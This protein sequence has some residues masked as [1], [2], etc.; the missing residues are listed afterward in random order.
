MV[1]VYLV[2]SP[3]VVAKEQRSPVV[4]AFDAARVSSQLA[5]VKAM[6]W[7]A[8]HKVVEERSAE[9]SGGAVDTAGS[10]DLLMKQLETVLGR[11][12]RPFEYHGSPEATAVFIAMGTSASKDNII[13]IYS[14]G[15]PE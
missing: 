14:L 2:I 12:Y 15:C 8:L 10:F 6:E 3:D 4:H 11:R 13:Y 7:A 1:L 9:G 5:H